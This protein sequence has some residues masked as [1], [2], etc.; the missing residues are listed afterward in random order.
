MGLAQDQTL[1]NF[2]EEG[3]LKCVRVN[4][5]FNNESRTKKNKKVNPNY[6]RGS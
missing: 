3:R 2:D 4:C 6:T 5:Q 1:S